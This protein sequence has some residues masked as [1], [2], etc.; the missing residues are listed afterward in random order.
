MYN[1]LLSISLNVDSKLLSIWVTYCSIWLM[2][3]FSNWVRVDSASLV[4]WL[5][6]KLAIVVF[7]NVDRIV[8]GTFWFW[9]FRFISGPLYSSIKSATWVLLTRSAYKN[10]KFDAVLFRSVQIWV[11]HWLSLI[12]LTICAE[13]KPNSVVISDWLVARKKKGFWKFWKLEYQSIFYTYLIN[14]M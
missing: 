6:S 1:K 2:I 7:R 12:D 13:I 14:K 3:K 5:M 4:C 11:L 8:N 9:P 10:G